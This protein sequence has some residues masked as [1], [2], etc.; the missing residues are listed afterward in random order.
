M[1]KNKK[2]S[3]SK[4]T[5]IPSVDFKEA[6][7]MGPIFSKYEYIPSFRTTESDA[8]RPYLNEVENQNWSFYLFIN[9]FSTN[10]P[11]M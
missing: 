4:H 5:T 11:L 6:I 8:N 3:T 7:M 10:V 1:I 9:P 2:L